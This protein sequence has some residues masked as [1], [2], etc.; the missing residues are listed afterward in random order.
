METRSQILTE[1]QEI[2]PQLGQ[3]GFSHIPYRVPSGY[4]TDFPD[5]L[6]IRIRLESGGYTENASREISEIS[7]L[8]SGLRNKI[9]YQAPEGFFESLHTKIPTAEN[10][11]PVTPVIPFFNTPADA[12]SLP[13]KRV[14]SLPMRVV[15]YAAAACITGLIG[16]A[17]FNITHHRNITDPIMSLTTISDKEMA[18]YLDADD[19]H[20]TPGVTSPKETASA[21]FSDDDIHDLLKGVPDVELEQ[22]SLALPEQ[23]GTVN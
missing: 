20:W 2:A 16:I 10:T 12:E 15:R 17:I 9:T 23:K 22:Y 18:N 5:L 6:M 14:I 7:P 21:D 1:L 8:L 19:I 11:S 4:F 13:G 3:G